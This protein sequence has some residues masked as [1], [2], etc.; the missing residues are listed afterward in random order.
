[1]PV[2][3]LLCPGRAAYPRLASPLSSQ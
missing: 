2:P 3:V 1:L